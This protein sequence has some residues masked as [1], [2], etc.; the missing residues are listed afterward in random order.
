MRSVSLA[1]GRRPR[2][3]DGFGHTTWRPRECRFG[4]RLF[5]FAFVAPAP[6]DTG[7]MLKIAIL[8]DSFHSC[9]RSCASHR[10]FHRAAQ[11]AQRGGGQ[12]RFEAVQEGPG[13]RL[14]IGQRG[15]VGFRNAGARKR[16]A[17]RAGGGIKAGPEAVDHH[18]R[19]PLRY[20]APFLPAVKAPQIVG[21]HDPDESDARAPGDKPFYRVIGVSRLDDSFETG[22][23]DARVM[24]ERA[25][26]RDALRQRGEPAGVLERIAR[27]DQPP[28][29]VEL[30]PF[31]RQQTG[32]EMRLMRRIERSAEQADPHAGRVGRKHALG[33]GVDLRCHGRI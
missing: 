31:E 4:Q 16:L 27:R 13:R 5:S 25:G 19:N 1:L 33:A 14:A 23:V 28:D 9:V 22:H 30:E 18:E 7:G 20:S 26:G 29:A 10:K 21:A 2:L 3:G 12:R 15:G 17:R 24:R 8:F 32:G 11:G 6:A